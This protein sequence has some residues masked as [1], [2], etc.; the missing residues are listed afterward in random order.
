[1]E[2]GTLLAAAAA[3]N[4]FVE[5]VKPAVREVVPEAYQKAALVALAL[6]AGL[7]VA[8]VGRLN[9]IGDALSLP[10]WIEIVLTGALVGAGA[11]ALNAVIDLLYSWRDQLR[12]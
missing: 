3:V 8:W 1:M 7:L 9:V 12:A 2:T 6:A 5:V 10:S 4:R 11:D